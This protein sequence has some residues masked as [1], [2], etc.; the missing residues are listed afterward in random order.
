MNS[1]TI[2]TIGT[3][4]NRAH[5]LGLTVE[6]LVEGQW[7]AGSVIALDG[8]GVVLTDRDLDHSV[9]RLE[10]VSAVRVLSTMPGR[11]QSTQGKVPTA[12]PMPT[13]RH[14]VKQGA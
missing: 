2:Y 9:V 4:L 11:E 13:T 6:V 12:R 3:A 7:L 14:L 5:Q 10:Q 1:S 8:H